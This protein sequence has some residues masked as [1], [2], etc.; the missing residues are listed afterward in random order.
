MI[1]FNN[2]TY[3]LTPNYHVQK[4]FMNHQGDMLLERELEDLGENQVTEPDTS[5]EILGVVFGGSVKY[6]NIQ[7]TNHEDNSTVSVAD[8]QLKGDIAAEPILSLASTHYTLTLD[9][10]QLEGMRGFYISFGQKSPTYKFAWE[11]GGWQNLDSQINDDRN[12]RVSC[13]TESKYSIETGRVYHLKLVVDGAHIQSYVD[14]ELINDVTVQPVV[15]EPLY[16][17]AR[18]M[19]QAILS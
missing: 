2:H 15:I 19:K 7:V 16:V 1:W 12:G 13:L 4:L 5:G 6:S 17:T 10:E 11:L 9:A 3:F 18:R 8:I 14:G